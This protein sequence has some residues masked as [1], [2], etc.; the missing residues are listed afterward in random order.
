M[1]SQMISVYKEYPI[2][3]ERRIDIVL[4]GNG[5]FIPVEVKI[6]AGEQQAQC[7]DYYQYAVKRDKDTY[8]VYLTLHG[9]MP[10]K[11]SLESKDGSYMLDLSNVKTISF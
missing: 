10:S 1:L 2:D 11:Y 7:C 5:R 9:T 6:Y 4:T 8:V 3:E